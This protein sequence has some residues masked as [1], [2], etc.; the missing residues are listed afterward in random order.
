MSA[1]TPQ[2]P[3]RRWPFL[4]LGATAFAVLMTVGPIIATRGVDAGGS[5][6]ELAGYNVGMMAARSAIAAQTAVIEVAEATT[7][8]DPEAVTAAAPTESQPAGAAEQPAVVEPAIPIQDDAIDVTLELS[9]PTVIDGTVAS[10]EITVTNQ[11][12]QYLWGVYAYL[13]GL[14]PVACGDRQLDIGAST[15]CRAD[16]VVWA[17]DNQAIAWATAWTVDRMAEEQTSLAYTVGY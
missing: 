1:P 6:Q 12:D 10:W 4:A 8:V 17:G 14:G 16:Q 9:D 5:D 7:P 2:Q 15:T 11:G 3:T 13:E